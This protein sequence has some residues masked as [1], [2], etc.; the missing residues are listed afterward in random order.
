MNA[1]R[2]VRVAALAASAVLMASCGGSDDT[3]IASTPQQTTPA[4]TDPTPAQ[5]G[6][7]AYL[8]A[9]PK[10]EAFSP[11][12]E[13]KLP[14][15]VGG[16]L[17]E[18]ERVDFPIK[19][20]VTGAV[21]AVR[22]EQYTCTTTKYSMTRTPEK[23]V[24]FS[25]DRELLWPGALIQGRSHRDGLGSLLALTIAERAPIKVS[26]PSLATSE[27]FRTVDTPDQA[28]VSQAIGAL[29]GN[30]T[31]QSLVAP[32]SIQ[33]TMS[34]YNSEKSFALN[35]GLSG[36]YLGFSGSASASVATSA[37]EHT[38]MVYFLE[39]M[40]EVVVEPPQ[41]PGSFFSADFTREKLDQQ[42]AM[43]RIGPD[44]LPV[45]VSNIVYGRIMAFTF[46]STAS[47]TDVQAALNAAY[48]G[49]FDASF[50]LDVKYKDIL[51]EGKIAV[52]SLGGSSSA[53]VAMI[54][55]GDWRQYFTQDAPLTSAYPISYTFRN[56]GDGSIAKVGESTEYSVRE[57]TPLN[58][59][60][61]MLDSFESLADLNWPSATAAGDP[62]TITWGNPATPQSIFYGYLKAQHVNQLND[63]YYKYDV[64]YIKSPHFTG[65]QSDYYRGELSF[66]LRPYDA[67]S[68]LGVR[69]YRHCYLALI[70]P[71]PPIF[72]Y[73]CVTLAQTIADDEPVGVND[74]VMAWD[75]YTTADQIVLRGGG[76]EPYEVLTLTYNPKDPAIALQW[77]KRSVSLS[78]DDLAGKSLCDAQ[79]K[80]C[81]L[82]EDRPATEHEIQYVLSNVTE[83]RVRASY[84]VL[85]T[86]K[87]CTDVPAPIPPSP[88]VKSVDSSEKIPLGYVGSYLDE[89]KVTK[90][91]TGF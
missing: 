66:W 50:N 37:N 54:A 45:Y 30:A 89:I 82:V 56:L 47:S 34:D 20:P 67:M 11:P 25:P 42:I 28:E 74:R 14:A 80:G 18:P 41:T 46:T 68:F 79:L 53:T 59:A 75:E 32:S 83:L 19:D 87:V 24:M 65:R 78:N 7:S 70:W 90:P 33:F 63:G 21:T 51:K 58:T 61:F 38:T 12:A 85:R 52:T 55:S 81:W 72:D 40:F 8:Q 77:Q 5:E 22:S 13:E 6:A 9:L 69:T 23:I 15:K 60:G 35:T 36:K 44:N 26:I 16:S 1:T 84:P 71:I 2:L 88:C 62:V 64:G 73:R 76:S 39:K 43:G 29:V 10:W 49:I 91:M 4:P 17:T 57:C 3:V 48:K 86:V 31:T 27:N